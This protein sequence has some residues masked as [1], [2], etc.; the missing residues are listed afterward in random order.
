[1]KPAGSCF[2]RKAPEMDSCG[3]SA[4]GVW[5]G[6]LHSP[7]EGKGEAGGGAKE[8]QGAIES[9]LLGSNYVGLGF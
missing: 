1:M 5:I 6:G 9:T 3:A 2:R 8:N 4:P 7:Y